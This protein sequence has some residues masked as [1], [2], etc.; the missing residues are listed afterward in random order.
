MKRFALGG[1]FITLLA[2]SLAFAACG[3]DDDDGGDSTSNIRTAN[4]LAVA[5]LVA[6]LNGG[7][8]N[9]GVGSDG[10]AA[11]A[12]SDE[13]ALLGDIAARSS[14]GDG[15]SMDSIGYG[16]AFQTAGG[17][18]ISAIGYGSATAD[19]DSA[20]L[21]F[22]FYNY[23]EPVPA[24]EPGIDPVP[25]TDGSSGSSSGSTGV[26]TPGSDI[27]KPVTITQGEVAPITEADLQPVID[28][29]N[30]AGATDVEFIGQTYYDVYSSSATIRATVANLDSVDAVV[31]AGADAAANLGNI[32]FSGNNVS[33]T[34]NDCAALERAAMEAAVEDAK[35]RAEILADVLGT[36]IGSVIGASDSSYTP[37]GGSSCSSGYYGPYPVDARGGFIEGGSSGVVV[38]SQVAVTYAIP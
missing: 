19:A 24:P 11:P 25:P 35:A 3:G 22:Y 31:Q 4:G 20:I 29:L 6:E 14:S 15:T 21:E 36:T 17:V 10:L 33:Y 5:N 26:D 30:A 12:A 23:G 32:Q 27:D 38:Y 7:N 18:G 8:L 2:L 37:Y 13:D 1:T 16:P 28:A 34:I 9:A